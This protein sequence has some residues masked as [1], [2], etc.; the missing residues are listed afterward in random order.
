MNIQK[1]ENAFNLWM[2]NYI[3]HPEDFTREFQSV[4]KHLGEKS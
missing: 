1:F 3:N 4:V 2:D